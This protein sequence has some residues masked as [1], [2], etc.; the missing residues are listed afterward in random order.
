MDLLI[1]IDSRFTPLSLKIQFAPPPSKIQKNGSSF[2]AYREKMDLLLAINLHL[3][4]N[5]PLLLALP[6]PLPT[7]L[8]LKIRFAPPTTKIQNDGSSLS[9]ARTSGRTSI[10][11]NS[12]RWL[13]SYRVSEKGGSFLSNWFAIHTSIVEN[14][15][16]T[17]GPH[18]YCWKFNSLL[19][20]H[21]YRRKFKRMAL[22][23]A[24]TRKRWIFS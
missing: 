9:A 18:I 1:T 3:R 23:L 20:P 13:L 4:G 8:L 7:P 12:K 16:L 6:E 11:E 19:C 17:L 14:S 22:V 5:I 10:L 24:H 15:I 2:S 21:L